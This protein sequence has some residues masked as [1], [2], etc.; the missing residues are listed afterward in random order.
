M[1][2][3]LIIG[4]FATPVSEGSLMASQHR[5]LQCVQTNLDRFTAQI[6]SLPGNPRGRAVIPTPDDLSTHSGTTNDTTHE[7]HYAALNHPRRHCPL[8]SLVLS[9]QDASCFP[10]SSQALLGAAL[11]RLHLRHTGLCGQQSCGAARRFYML[12]LHG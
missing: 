6:C 2:F 4:E 7:P 12:Q 10:G 5:T 8:L 11:V 1:C 3:D 9:E